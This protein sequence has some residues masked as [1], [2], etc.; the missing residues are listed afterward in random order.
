MAVEEFTW[1][2]PLHL[3]TV[4]TASWDN[5]NIIYAEGISFKTK[6]YSIMKEMSIE[7]VTQMVCVCI[8]IGS[9]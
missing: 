9:T 3:P 2:S 4:Q 6:Q 7:W 5:Q 8:S 1:E